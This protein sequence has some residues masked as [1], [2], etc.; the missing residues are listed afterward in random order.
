MG[1]NEEVNVGKIPS[2]NYEKTLY[3]QYQGCRQGGRFMA[4]YI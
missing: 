1:K 3:N 4:E 2:P